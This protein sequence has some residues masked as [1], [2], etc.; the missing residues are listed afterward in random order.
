MRASL[1]QCV[2]AALPERSA[3][4]VA[5]VVRGSRQGRWD[6]AAKA[7]PPSEGRSGHVIMPTWIELKP[8][9]PPDISQPSFSQEDQR[10]SSGSSGVW[11]MRAVFK[12]M[13][14]VR[15]APGAEDFRPAHAVAEVEV[16]GNVLLRDR[17][18]NC[19]LC[20]IELGVRSEQRQ[21][22]ADAGVNAGLLVVVKTPT[23]FGSVP[24]P[25][26]IRIVPWSTVFSIP[27]RF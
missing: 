10:P 14:Q 26:V 4:S 20:R 12:N 13:P 1:K 16:R 11:P 17:L 22:T 5:V 3:T 25:R 19:Q 24:L 6:V 2:N 7:H 15:V 8:A 21:F 23:G 18:K 9:H 27:G